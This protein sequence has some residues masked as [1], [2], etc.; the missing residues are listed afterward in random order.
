MASQVVDLSGVAEFDF[1]MQG[2]HVY[3]ND[4][5]RVVDPNAI[6]FYFELITHHF[7]A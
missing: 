2:Y 4:W 7:K 5:S 3:S 1:L 6:R